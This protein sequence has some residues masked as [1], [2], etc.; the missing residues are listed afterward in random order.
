MTNKKAGKFEWNQYDNL[1][2]RIREVTTKLVRMQYQGKPVEMIRNFDRIEILP[3]RDRVM[4]VVNN[5]Q[6]VE[7][8]IARTIMIDKLSME[9]I[10][11]D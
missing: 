8:V 3:L 2:N 6:K 7:E 11:V 4:L 1:Y 9:V 10:A 5:Q